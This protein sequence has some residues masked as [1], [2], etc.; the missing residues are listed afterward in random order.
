MTYQSLK[1]ASRGICRQWEEWHEKGSNHRGR[2]WRTF[3]SVQLE[4]LMDERG[5]IGGYVSC[6][7]PQAPFRN[8]VDIQG[9]LVAHVGCTTETGNFQGHLAN[10]VWLTYD[11]CPLLP[12]RLLWCSSASGHHHQEVVRGKREK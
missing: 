7:R 10:D 4:R 6:H 9:L 12:Y 8:K 11:S 1:V 3:H 2:K 5:R